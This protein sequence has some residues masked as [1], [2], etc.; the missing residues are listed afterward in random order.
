ME[1]FQRH[2]SLK[3]RISLLLLAVLV[4]LVPVLTGC[5]SNPQLTSKQRLALIEEIKAFELKLGFTETDNFKEYAGDLESYPYYFYTSATELPYS[6]DDPALKNGQGKPGDAGLD[7]ER[8]DI[9]FYEIPS[10]AGVKTPVTK[11]LLREPLHRFIFIIF[12]EDWHEQIDLPL[13]IEESSGEVI[14]YAAAM[15]FV[16]ERFGRDSLVYK[17]L[18]GELERKVKTSHIFLSYYDELT[19]LYSAFHR[20]A[21]SEA[22]TLTQKKRLLEAMSAAFISA[23]RIK[24]DQLNNA[25]I[26]FQMTY[27][28]HLPLMY[29]VFLATG[30]DVYQTVAIFKA[31]PEQ[32]KG[33]TTL[34]EV[35]AIENSVTAYLRNSAMK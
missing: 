26:A 23:A 7:P 19:S 16:G 33:A 24:F 29:E 18:Q 31:M 11:L 32:G 8:Y 4:A 2:K 10:I 12:H 20:G 1:M 3:L 25:F 22:E 9:F 34:D 6:L 17:D 15:L 28:R 13:G 27:T 35:K 5:V 14:G 30:E 21:I